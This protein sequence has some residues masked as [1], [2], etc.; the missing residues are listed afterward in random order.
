MICDWHYDRPIPPPPTRHERLS[1]VTCPGKTQE[2]G[3]PGAGH[4]PVP[5]T[6]GA[7]MK[8]RFMAW[9]RPSGPTPRVHGG[10]GAHKQGGTDKAEAKTQANCFVTLS[11][12]SPVE[13]T[14]S[15]LAT[16]VRALVTEYE[17][18]AI[19]PPFLR[20]VKLRNFLSF[21]RAADGR[22]EPNVSTVG[23]GLETLP[24]CRAQPEGLPESSRW[25]PGGRATTEPT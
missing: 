3:R 13:E 10:I 8:D 12:K 17:R 20:Q 24:L 25:S 22:Q 23:L 4:G 1:V 16:P 11:R 6:L 5:A 2:R 7:P 19:A 9:S 21:V 15:W 18:P 14:L